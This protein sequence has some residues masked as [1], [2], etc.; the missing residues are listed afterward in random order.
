[1][2]VQHQPLPLKEH[3]C[4]TLTFW[5]SRPVCASTFPKHPL[6][7]KSTHIRSN[8]L[9]FTELMLKVCSGLPS[10]FFSVASALGYPSYLIVAPKALLQHPYPWFYRFEP[11]VGRSHLSQGLQ[12]ERLCNFRLLESSL[13]WAHFL[14]LRGYLDFQLSCLHS[15]PSGHSPIAHWG[16]A[17]R[18][19]W[20]RIS[21][22][23]MVRCLLLLAPLPRLWL[24]TSSTD[25]NRGTNPILHVDR[26][27]PI[28]LTISP[29]PRR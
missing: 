26:S 2:K 25:H 6:L 20:L 24:S 13:L 9:A 11:Q 4:N 16:P 12:A 3:P 5:L 15:L 10:L 18:H 8:G 22:A 27:L 17:R 28:N 19:C 1:M 21:N 7:H 14:V 29:P 23:T